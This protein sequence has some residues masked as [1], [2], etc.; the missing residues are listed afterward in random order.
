MIFKKKIKRS[1]CK[2]EHHTLYPPL[3]RTRHTRLWQLCWQG[4]ALTL[5]SELGGQ[6]ARPGLQFGFDLGSVLRIGKFHIK[7]GASLAP[8]ALLCLAPLGLAQPL[9]LSLKQGSSPSDS[10]GPTDPGPGPLSWGT[11][12][13]RVTGYSLLPALRC[14][15]CGPHLPC[16]PGLRLR[17]AGL[18]DSLRTAR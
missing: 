14:L 10:P 15:V 1:Y 18:H 4:E 11:P 17:D 9:P 12:R 16:P 5:G 8:S 2:G 6:G 7:S 13:L 3:T